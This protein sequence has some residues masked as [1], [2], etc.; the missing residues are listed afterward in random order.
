MSKVTPPKLNGTFINSG[1]IATLI[2][3]I[4]RV[5]GDSLITISALV[6]KNDLTDFVNDTFLPILPLTLICYWLVLKYYT[7]CV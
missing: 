6:D 2:G 1:L 4:G 7:L 5:S 3:T